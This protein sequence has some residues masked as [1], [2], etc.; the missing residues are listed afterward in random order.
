MQCAPPLRAT[1]TGGHF[2][3][4]REQDNREWPDTFN[5]ACEYGPCPAA[6]NGFLL[7]FTLRG[8]CNHPIE[9]RHHAK[10]FYGT[11]GV[12]AM[13]R[14]GYDIYPQMRDGKKTVSE[15]S[16][17]SAKSEHEVCQDHMKRFFDCMRSRKRPEADI[18][19]GHQFSVPGHLMNISYR[20]GRPVRWDARAERIIDDPQ[21]D[22]LVTKQYRAPWKL[23]ELSVASGYER[24]G[25]AAW[26]REL[27]EWAVPRRDRA[28]R[29]GY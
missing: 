28:G 8:G 20:V 29:G 25:L 17:R 16:V 1:G 5:G 19:V 4:S 11:D 2:A 13:D 24:L 9:K 18:E 14:G 21:A 27:Y 12:L 22:A 7:S 6:K 3:F 26:P 15:E 23:P 10:A